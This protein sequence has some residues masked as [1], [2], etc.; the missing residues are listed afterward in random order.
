M[1]PY[2]SEPMGFEKFALAPSHP[3]YIERCDAYW[4]DHWPVSMHLTQYTVGVRWAHEGKLLHY[5]LMEFLP[6]F[7]QIRTLTLLLLVLQRFIR[8]KWLLHGNNVSMKKRTWLLSM[9]LVW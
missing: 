7:C 3:C 6:V 9:I 5:F 2:F 1:F 4:P 8:E